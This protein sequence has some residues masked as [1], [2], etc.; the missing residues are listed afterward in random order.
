MARKS[1][2]QAPEVA[3]HV[4]STV[5]KHICISQSAS[6]SEVYSFS[7][8]YRWSPV[9]PCDNSPSRSLEA[10]LVGYPLLNISSCPLSYT[11]QGMVPLSSSYIT[12]SK[13]TPHRCAQTVL[14]D[15]PRYHQVNNP[16]LSKGRRIRSSGLS[17][18]TWSAALRSLRRDNDKVVVRGLAD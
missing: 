3:G 16:E 17:S 1:R 8:R 11:V 18:D 9:W 7:S 13:I 10:P 5:R 2:Q 15:D 12:L 6:C 14:I 4:S